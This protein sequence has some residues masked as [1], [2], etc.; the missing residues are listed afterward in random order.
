MDYSSEVLPKRWKMPKTILSGL[1]LCCVS[2]YAGNPADGLRFML[3]FRTSETNIT[4]VSVGNALK[5][6]G[7][8]ASAVTVKGGSTATN[9][10]H[11]VPVKCVPPMYPWQTNDVYALCLPQRTKYVENNPDMFNAKIKDII[12]IDGLRIVFDNGFALV[13][14]SNTEPVFTLR[15]EAD[16]QLSCDITEM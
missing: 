15:F 16:S 10:V 2:A 9:K 14:Q 13:R 5:A 4:S 6:S 7:S 1:L 3:D 8:P 12:T 11:Q